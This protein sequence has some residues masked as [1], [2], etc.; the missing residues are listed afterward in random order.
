MKGQRKIKDF[1][2]DRKIPLETRDR[3]PIMTCKGTPLW[4]CGFRID[5]RFKVTPE[6]KKMLR[7]KMKKRVFFYT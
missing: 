5:D 2:I 6:T 7:I 4:L 3:T 1:F